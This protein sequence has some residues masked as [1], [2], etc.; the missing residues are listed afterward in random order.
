MT[1]PARV[2]VSRGRHFA[3]WFWRCPACDDASW[4]FAHHPEALLSA[5]QHATRCPAIRAAH[6]THIIRTAHALACCTDAH[7]SVIEALEAGL[8]PRR[9]Q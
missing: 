4:D 8:N 7:I 3:W 1:R 5:T 6:L 9:E 2:R